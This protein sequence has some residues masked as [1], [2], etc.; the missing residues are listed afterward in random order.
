MRI[1]VAGNRLSIRKL[2]LGDAPALQARVSEPEITQWTTRIPHPYPEGGARCF[3]HSATAQWR[4][5]RAYIFGIV[6]ADATEPC[7]VVSLSAVSLP[8]GCAELG[9]WLGVE[10]WGKGLATEAVGL[11]L[12]FAFG[13]LG[14]F[15]VYASTFAANVASRRVLEKNGFQLEGVLR[16]AVVRYGQRHD[17]LNFG[18]LRPDWEER[19]S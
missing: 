14:L 8:H 1:K 12:R 3:I 7:G 15:R 10:S 2:R 9:Y 16:A 4:L 13:D 11:A 19:E 17:Y 18:L 5:G 6:P